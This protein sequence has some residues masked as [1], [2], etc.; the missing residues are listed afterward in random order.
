MTEDSRPPGT[1]ALVDHLEA[2]YGDR[3]DDERLERLREVVAERREAGETLEEAGLENGDGP[4][5]PF[6]PYRGGE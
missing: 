4:A 5:P 3:F 1:D 6:R 2:R